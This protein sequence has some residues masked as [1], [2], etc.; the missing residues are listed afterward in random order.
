MSHRAAHHLRG[1]TLPS[2]LG[3]CWDLSLIKVA[4]VAEEL[5][6]FVTLVC[7]LLKIFCSLAN[8]ELFYFPPVWVITLPWSI[9]V[10]LIS[11]LKPGTKLISSCWIRSLGYKSSKPS[12]STVLEHSENFQNVCVITPDME[13]ELRNPIGLPPQ[14]PLL[15]LV[16]HAIAQYL[17]SVL[18][19]I[20]IR[21]CFLTLNEWFSFLFY[22]DKKF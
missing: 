21:T 5:T 4:T 10:F 8:S 9:P 11:G 14:P 16:L 1:Q 3:S 6:V 12:M 13:R 7:F 15:H 2:P 18:S 20:W 17:L 22:C 19:G